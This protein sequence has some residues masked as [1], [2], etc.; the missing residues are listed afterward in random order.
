MMKK[1]LVK[2]TNSYFKENNC[3]INESE[4][5]FA[6]HKGE[7]LLE[8][9]SFNSGEIEFN[10]VNYLQDKILKVINDLLVV[11]YQ[12]LKKYF[13]IS[14]FNIDGKKILEQLRK[15]TINHYLIRMTFQNS[16]GTKSNIHIYT[17]G[18]RGQGYLK[19]NKIQ[20]RFLEYIKSRSVCD[21]K[22][23]LVINQTVLNIS[24]KN[25]G[26]VHFFIEVYHAD[27]GILDVLGVV[28]DD[29]NNKTY[30]IYPVRNIE[31]NMSKLQGKLKCMEKLIYNEY[32]NMYY[33]ITVLIVA[34][35]KE[36][37]EYYK[38]KLGKEYHYLKLAITYDSLINSKQ[39]NVE[40][41]HHI[42]HTSLIRKI[43]N[44][45]YNIEW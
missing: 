28:N 44:I 34:E 41:I 5:P 43:L 36:W 35:N 15:L 33:D 27:N 6:Y 20:P 24:E 1:F 31:D 32:L 23:I 2:K 37:M 21:I 22:K 3:K 17:I 14:G 38:D 13:V 11:N 26:S 7:V 9:E 30:L 16:D 40:K 4:N 45:I 10:S 42:K 39:D 25:K 8:E 12:I 18:K 29:I 19:F